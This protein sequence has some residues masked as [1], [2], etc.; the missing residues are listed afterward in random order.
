MSVGNRQYIILRR[1]I[2]RLWFNSKARHGALWARQLAT[3]SR[4]YLHNAVFGRMQVSIVLVHAMIITARY[5][6]G[7]RCVLDAVKFYTMSQGGS[8]CYCCGDAGWRRVA[9]CCCF[10]KYFA[11]TKQL[12]GVLLHGKVAMFRVVERI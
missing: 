2:K 12:K 7:M 6:T 9:L 11:V 3:E 1:V 10:K 8:E 5:S 4:G